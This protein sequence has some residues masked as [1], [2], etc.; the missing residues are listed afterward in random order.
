MSKPHILVD[1]DNV[2]YPFAKVMSDVIWE[3]T[4]TSHSPITLRK[5]Y[6]TWNIWDDWD[7]PKGQFDWWWEKAIRDGDMYAKGKP[8]FNGVKAMWKLSDMGWHIHIV[9]SRLNKFRLHDQSVRATADWLAEYGIP[10]RSLTFTAEKY[11][12]LADVIVD[13]N[14]H[15]LN[16]HPAPEKFL[17]PAPHNGDEQTPEGI[18]RLKKQAPWDD[19]IERLTEE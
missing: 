2:L 18:V 7:V 8:I 4:D 12:I 10:Y 3:N 11:R 16:N 6:K 5:L 14:P 13:D 1:L 15:N 17:F 19:L 9:T